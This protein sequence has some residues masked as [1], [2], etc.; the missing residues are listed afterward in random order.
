MKKNDNNLLEMKGVELRFDDRIILDQLNL[1]VKAQD[2]LVVMGL[3]GGGK[4]TL[5]RLILGLLKVNAGSIIFKEKEITTLKDSELNKVRPHIGMVYQNAALISSMTVGENIALPMR[6]LTHKSD[7]EIDE[8]VEQKLELVGLKDIKEKLPSELSGG[9]A[10]RV[11]L[12]RA[13]ALDPELILFDEPSAGLDPINSTLIDE[14]IVGLREEHKV[15]SIVVT[16]ELPSAFA[17]ATQ[18]AML[19]EG[20][21]I[22]EGNP[23][24]FRNSE[25]PLVSEFLG[26]Y[27]IHNKTKETNH[28]NP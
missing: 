5:L 22:L 12:A 27:S 23:E 25:I 8:T 18:M 28:A 24:I 14:L 20:K 16:H 19:N 11:G 13:L 10:K 4:S 2:T 21:I 6:E 3:S 26:S 15:T 9:M 7:K 17:I 1:C